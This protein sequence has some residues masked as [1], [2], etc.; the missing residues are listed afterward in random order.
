MSSP[1]VAIAVVIIAALSGVTEANAFRRAT[2]AALG[3]RVR[4]E[5]VEASL[6]SEL[7]GAVG[8]GAGETKVSK[9]AADLRTM[10]AALPKNEA[11]GLG[12]AAVRYALH[13]YFVKKHGWFVKGLDPAG[14]ARN[15]TSGV[16]MLKARVPEYIEGLFEVRLGGRG[17][18]LEELA[19]LAA[20]L[21]H[22]V[23]DEAIQRLQSAYQ[24]FSLPTTDRISGDELAKVIDVYMMVYII[25][26]DIA[27][28]DQNQ[29]RVIQKDI[30]E[31]YPGWSDTQVWLR[32]MQGSVAYNHRGERNPF[33]AGELDFYRSAQ[34]VEEI[35]E[36][37]GGFQDLECR[38]LKRGLMDREGEI[39]GRVPLSEFYKSRDGNFLFTESV[40]YLRQSGALDESDEKKP[41]VIMTNYLTSPSNCL[42][43]SSFYSVC[44]LDECEGLMEKLESE[45]GAPTATPNQISG[46][47]AALPSDTVEVPRVLSA[48]L[49]RR[50]DEIAD[51]H[52]GHI[53]LHG[54]LFAQWMH[55]AYPRE[56]PYPHVAGTTSQQ[57]GAWTEV[58][59][60]EE[61]LMYTKVTTLDTFS[62]S[63]DAKLEALP[64]ATDEE[65]LDDQNH[66]LRAAPTYRTLFAF[67]GNLL[68]VGALLSVIYSLARDSKAALLPVHNAKHGKYSV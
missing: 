12:H 55:H 34:I 52:E 38:N 36:R 10:Y 40:Q 58:A 62:L 7:A 68:L 4:V 26:G 46:T 35:G 53:P 3:E 64:W 2:P 48:P 14:A 33:A 65:L 5:D 13:R 11:G 39:P 60:E 61:M 66:I 43:T 22:L 24:A 21:E 50:L 18:G 47:V 9:I 23:H 17:L 42:T 8:H 19:I 49:I 25:G 57:D 6:L 59:S 16:E 63:E 1:A 45:I 30:V 29:V 44:C 28:M 31:M 27:T 67:L 56:C 15:T 20:T 37:Y 32:D 41:S 54:R 51:R